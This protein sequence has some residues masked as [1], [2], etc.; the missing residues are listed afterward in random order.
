MGRG[1]S[2]HSCRMVSGGWRLDERI[3][4]LGGRIRALRLARR[5]SQVQLA[6]AVGIRQHTLSKVETGG[7]APSLET[8]LAIADALGVAPATL[9]GQPTSP[10]DV[11]EAVMERVPPGDATIRDRLRAALT[12]LL[13]DG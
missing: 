9:L 6:E 3:A 11:V 2:A 5:M 4:E 8:M 7:G 13:A 1:T 10:V 12:T